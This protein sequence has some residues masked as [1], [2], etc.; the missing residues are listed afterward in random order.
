MAFPRAHQA[1][2]GLEGVTALLFLI[3]RLG[4]YELSGNA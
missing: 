1:E 3:S 2:T 4:L